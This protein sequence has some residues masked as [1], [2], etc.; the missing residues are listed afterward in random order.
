MKLD[1][2]LIGNNGVF[3]ADVAECIGFIFARSGQ[4]N[5]IH[6]QK[7]NTWVDFYNYHRGKVSHVGHKWRTKDIWESFKKQ[8]LMKAAGRVVMSMDHVAAGNGVTCI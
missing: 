4:I 2:I 8:K 5:L 1:W 7:K 3:V 6:L